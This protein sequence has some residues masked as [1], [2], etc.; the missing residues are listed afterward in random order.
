MCISAVHFK[1]LRHIFK[2]LCIYLD[3]ILTVSIYLRKYSRETAF[4][5]LQ[6]PGVSAE[7]AIWEFDATFMN[8]QE[9]MTES[10]HVKVPVGT[11]KKQATESQHGGKNR[12][13]VQNHFHYTSHFKTSPGTEMQNI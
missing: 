5:I 3:N 12:M 1:G 9:C 8:D 7:R 10:V 6:D 2:S 11:V 4:A 13:E